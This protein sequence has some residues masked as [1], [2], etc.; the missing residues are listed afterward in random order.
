[1]S[2]DVTVHPFRRTGGSEWKTPSQH[3][4]KQHAERIEIAPGIDRAIHSSGLLGSHIRKRTSN[5]LGWFRSLA[6]PGKPRTD[7]KAHEPAL[8]GIRG[9]KYVGRLDVLMD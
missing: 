3:F 2:S 4:V 9:Y 7:P 8:A 5:E 1:M 6:L